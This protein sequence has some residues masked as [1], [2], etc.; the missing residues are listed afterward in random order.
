MGRELEGGGGAQWLC[1]GGGCGRLVDGVAGAAR[2]FAMQG[3][4]RG[5]EGRVQVLGVREVQGG[6]EGG[7][8]ARM[9]VWRG[10]EVEL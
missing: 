7:A 2:G 3:A 5:E 1:L 4:C 6:G 10:G 8:G 9:S